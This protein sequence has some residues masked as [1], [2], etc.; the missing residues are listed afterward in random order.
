MRFAVKCVNDLFLT[1]GNFTEEIKAFK[2]GIAEFG[3]L[4]EWEV[5]VIAR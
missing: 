1:Y 2:F 3:N 4:V 5:V